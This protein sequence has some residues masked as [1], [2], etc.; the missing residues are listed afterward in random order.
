MPLK[1]DNDILLPER[2]PRGTFCHI[3]HGGGKV[4][5]ARVALEIW[6]WCRNTAGP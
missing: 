6:G 1:W 2:R 4:T 5:E 3:H